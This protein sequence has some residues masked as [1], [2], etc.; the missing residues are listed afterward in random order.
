M[1]EVNN[2][3][4]TVIGTV[5][6]DKMDK[7]VVVEVERVF[8]HPF[9]HKVVRTSKRYKAHDEDNKCCAGDLVSIMETRRLSRDK[10]WRVVEILGKAKIKTRELPKQ[11]KVIKEAV[12]AGETKIET[13]VEENK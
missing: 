9:Y 3:A 11:R 12:P 5:V 8:R 10:R 4:R 6:S 1:S 2:E 7:T 13:S